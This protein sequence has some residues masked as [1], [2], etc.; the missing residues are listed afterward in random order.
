MYRKEVRD[1]WLNPLLG[2]CI[3]SVIFLP[4]I[5]TVCYFF[6]KYAFNSP[7]GDFCYVEKQTGVAY[8]E[9]VPF[10][11]NSDNI[12]TKWRHW[13]MFNLIGI[14]VTNLFTWCGVM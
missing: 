3:F 9:P 8:I 5:G 12:S 10:E 13:F 14:A 6:W 1:R 4:I 11:E 7:D 2:I